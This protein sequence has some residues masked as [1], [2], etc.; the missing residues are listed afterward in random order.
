MTVNGKIRAIDMRFLDDL[1]AMGG[2]YVLD[3]TNRTFAEFFE[4][5]LGINID[6][7]RYEAEGTSKARRLRY[8][9]RTA[10]RPTVVRTLLALWEY[11]EADRRRSGLEETVP[12][13]EEEFFH[14]IERLGGKP[15]TT[16]K[17]PVSAE[18][19]VVPDQ[20]LVS[21]LSAKLTEV[22][23]LKPQERGY[24]FER[25]LKEFFDASGLGARASF[26]LRGEQID[27]SF[28]LDSE[29][30]LLEARWRNER[31]AN[32]DLLTF[33]GKIAGK[34]QWS[35]GLFVSYAGFS[36][37]G[38]QGFGHGRPTNL[39]GLD[40]L[41]LYHILS[42]TLDLREVLRRKVRRAAE[43]NRVFVPV[44]ELFPNVT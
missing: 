1:F 42:G 35:R 20:A 21:K 30:Y 40:G 24:A 25:F 28:E 39:I 32:S 22:S 5:E 7:P 18:T 33:G 44:R 11:R 38:L 12:N 36:E 41:D 14:F 23:Q 6:E 2:G 16:N 9:L 34:A 19:L 8:F 26:R 27:G 15:P 43:T 31:A 29:V 3:F 10:D 17:P 4:D 37:D 13:A